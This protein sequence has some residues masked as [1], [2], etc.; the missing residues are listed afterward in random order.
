MKDHSEK[1]GM[2]QVLLINV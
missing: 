1:L 2:K